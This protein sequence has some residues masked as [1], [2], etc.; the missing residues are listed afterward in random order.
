ML[1]CGC[2]DVLSADSSQKMPPQLTARATHP[3][4][5]HSIELQSKAA[6][7]ITPKSTNCHGKGKKDETDGNL[8]SSVFGG[9][10]QPTL[11]E[12]SV[13]GLKSQVVK[14]RSCLGKRV[15]RWRGW[16]VLVDDHD[17]WKG[18]S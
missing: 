10:K 3:G 2:L 1:D 17:E 14:V 8:V 7:L 12:A 4:Q 11:K 18:A 13:A 16:V 9:L 6:T 15:E 5:S